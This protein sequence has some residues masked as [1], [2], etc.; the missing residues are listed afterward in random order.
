MR[1]LTAVL[2][3]PA[4]LFLGAC[5]GANCGSAGPGD[6]VHVDIGRA[7]D[8]TPTADP[9]SCTVRHGT[10]V[11]WRGP[12]FDNDDFTLVFDQAP[13]TLKTGSDG[14]GRR[15]VSYG[16]TSEFF[17]QKVQVTLDGPA[18]DY[19]YDVRTARGTLDPHVIIER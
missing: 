12:W 2:V 16:S 11:T 17:R 18:R 8:G 1:L 6:P 4:C 15:G 13:G 19:K 3:A 10:V 9:G 5:D 14:S 7:S